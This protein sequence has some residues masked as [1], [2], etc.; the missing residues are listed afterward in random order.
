MAHGNSNWFLILLL[1]HSTLLLILRVLS[2]NPR[3]VDFACKCLVPPVEESLDW[4]AFLTPTHTDRSVLTDVI[5]LPAAAVIGLVVV[6]W[7]CKR[8]Y[9]PS[10]LT[11]TTSWK[12]NFSAEQILFGPTEQATTIAGWPLPM[13]LM[14]LWHCCSRR[15]PGRR[16]PF[17]KSIFHGHLAL[18]RKI[19]KNSVDALC[20]PLWLAS[21]EECVA[22]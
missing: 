16:N 9:G 14:A 13:A 10:S 6:S 17:L 18:S 20:S 2:S 5:L 19:R 8:F 11:L 21:T 15:L 3:G 12:M 22:L 4:S 7:G 1:L